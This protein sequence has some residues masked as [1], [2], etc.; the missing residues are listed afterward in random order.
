[1]AQIYN[2]ETMFEQ[3]LGLK[4]PWRVTKAVFEEQERTVHIYISGRKTAE[5]PC[6]TACAQEAGSH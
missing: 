3:S 2:F 6:P 1:M 5:Y 4:E